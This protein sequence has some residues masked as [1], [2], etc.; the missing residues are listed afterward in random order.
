MEEKKI[1]ST[2][3]LTK[4]YSEEELARIHAKAIKDADAELRKIQIE[5]MA[6]VL[7]EYVGEKCKTCPYE[8]ATDLS[9][10]IVKEECEDLYAAGYRKSSD[11]AREIIDILKSTGIDEWRYRVIAEIKKKY[12][13]GKG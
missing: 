8:H 6:R 3:W 10:C 2:D 9:V 5:E 13:E 11:T 12:E 7:C 1:K 4:G